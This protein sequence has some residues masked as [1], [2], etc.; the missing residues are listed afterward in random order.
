M[1]TEEAAEE[2]LNK[3]AFIP[4]GNVFDAVAKRLTNLAEP[5]EDNDAATLAWVRSRLG[6]DG[7]LEAEGWADEAKEHALTVEMIATQFGNVEEAVTAAR[8][9]RDG[10]LDARD[11]TD[12]LRSET[13]GL[14]NDTDALKA[15]TLTARDT[16]ISASRI[17]QFVADATERDALTVASGHRVFM[18]SDRHLWQYNG[19]TWDDEGPDDMAVMLPIVEKRAFDNAP[20]AR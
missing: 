6:I 16:A 17:D 20:I 2:A 1:K 7:A 8:D 11:L 19:S 15:D 5:E 18:R 10:A 13:V 9:A 3:L 14:K 12:S 4:E